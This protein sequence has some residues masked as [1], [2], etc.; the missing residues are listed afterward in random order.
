[1][2]KVTIQQGNVITQQMIDK[3]KPGMTRNQVAFIMGQPVLKNTFDANRWDYVYTIE[4]PGRFQ[5]DRRVS[6]FFDGD[7]LSYFTG[8][9]RP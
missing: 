1:M 9:L 6:L 7:L 3:L 4:V 2:H 5:Q 8:D